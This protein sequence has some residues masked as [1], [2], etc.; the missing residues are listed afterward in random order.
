M[1]KV[2]IIIPVYNTNQDYLE[3]CINSI[4]NQSFC[5]FEVIVVD[6]GSADS[7]IDSINK[8]ADLDSRIKVYHQE[9]KGASVARNTGIKYAVGEYITFVDSDDELTPYFLEMAYGIAEA[10]KADIVYGFEIDSEKGI[11]DSVNDKGNR[12][13]KPDDEWLKKYHVGFIYKEG[14]KYLG[15][16]PVA[17]L[18]RT[19]IAQSVTFPEGILIGEDVIWNL[20]LIPKAKVKYAT[21]AI[22]YNYIMRDSSRTHK[23]CTDIEK[24]VAPFHLALESYL[25]T[26]ETDRYYYRMR[27]FR[28]LYAYIFECY[29]GHKENNRTFVRKWVQFNRISSKYP[30]NIL[31]GTLGLKCSEGFIRI[32]GIIKLVLFKTRMMY[33]FFC[34]LKKIQSIS[35]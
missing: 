2:S 11:G 27:L 32:S 4:L 30:W 23:Y 28:D 10:K 12:I 22:W 7:F 13:W 9:N 17:R 14:K 20:A 6:D 1:I 5:C 26:T 3:N 21:D 15:R 8:L 19:E 16:G 35:S 33:P 34:V 29:L 18:I 25:S 24:S 31:N